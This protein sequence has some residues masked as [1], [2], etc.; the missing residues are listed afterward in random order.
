MLSLLTF[1]FLFLGQ[2]EVK[3]QSAPLAVADADAAAVEDDGVLDDGEPQSCASE[4]PASPLVDAVEALEEARQ[5]LLG[6]AAT[7]VGDGKLP[8]AVLGTRLDIDGRLLSRIGQGV[9]DEVAEDTVDHAP[10]APHRQLGGQRDEEPHL[11][12]LKLQC[13]LLLYLPDHL[14]DVHRLLAVQVLHLVHDVERRDVG[15]QRGEPL[16]LR[17]A[18]VE[19]HLARLL[20]DRGMVDE[21]LQ[22]ALDARHGRLQLVGDVVGELAFEFVLLPARALVALIDLDDALGDVAQ[23][24]VGKDRQVLDVERLVVVGPRGEEP[25]FGDVVAQSARE[26]VEQERQQ[27]DGAQRKPKIVF[28]RVEHAGEVVV[29]GQGA[30]DDVA[31]GGKIGGGVEESLRHGGALAL[32][33]VAAAVVEGLAHLLA[34]G[35]VVDVAQVLLPRV[36]EDRAVGADERHAQPPHV[37][38]DDVAVDKRLDVLRRRGDGLAHL[39][40]EVLE[41]RV[42]HRH[43]VV[44]LPS[45]L[46]D[47]EGEGKEQEDGEHPEVEAHSHGDA[48][49]QRREGRKPRGPLGGPLLRSPLVVPLRSPLVVPLRSPLVSSLV[50]PWRSL[51]VVLPHPSVSYHPVSWSSPQIRSRIPAASRYARHRPSPCGAAA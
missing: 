37:V 16:A 18:A 39:H 28:V 3:L 47:D 40:V 35:V 7:R 8:I 36:V 50:V 26:V 23:L 48:G 25:Q 29:V 46:I 19:K 41:A 4:R 43:L 15:Q 10:H 14:R 20:V 6:H 9:V 17:V 27:H 31:V 45:L 12:L 22:V 2:G 21:R 51:L 5:M 11:P 24:V 49:A 30:A 13:R 34:V 32:D 38:V 44:L 42:E 33:G 1:V